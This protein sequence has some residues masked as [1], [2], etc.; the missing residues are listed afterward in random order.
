[1]AILKLYKKPAFTAAKTA[2]L[3]QKLQKRNQNVIGL[4]TELCFYVEVASD[5]K[6]SEAERR[7]L[8]WVLQDPFV[9]GGVSETENFKPTGTDPLIEVSFSK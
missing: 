3:L 1:M 9:P 4:E 5:G 2:E 8:K 6:L 7:V